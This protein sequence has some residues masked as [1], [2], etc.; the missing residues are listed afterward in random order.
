[1]LSLPSPKLCL[2]FPPHLAEMVCR[3][4]TSLPFPVPPPNFNQHRKLENNSPPP[5]FP[6]PT[7]RYPH[8]TTPL[9]SSPPHS[10]IFTTLPLCQSYLNDFCCL[11]QKDCVVPTRKRSRILSADS[12]PVTFHRQG[13]LATRSKKKIP[14]HTPPCKHSWHPVC[15]L[16]GSARPTSG[17]QIFLSNFLPIA[18]LQMARFPMVQPWMCEAPHISK[19]LGSHSVMVTS[20]LL[21]LFPVLRH[22]RKYAYRFP[23]PH[24][25]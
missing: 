17:F 18:L 20:F 15:L 14:S 3:Q 2:L 22:L 8:R 24:L 25:C 9:Q 19:R 5:F 6:S 11:R 23:C 13:P 21:S 7:V 16:I 4:E 1:M 12:S 10:L